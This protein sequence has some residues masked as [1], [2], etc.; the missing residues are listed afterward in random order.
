MK[1]GLQTLLAGIVITTAVAGVMKLSD[2]ETPPQIVINE[3]CGRNGTI[4]LGNGSRVEDYIELYNTTDQTICLEDWCLSDDSEKLDKYRLGDLT[5]APHGFLILYA[6]GEAADEYSLNFKISASGENLFLTDPEGT[7]ADQIYVPELEMDCVYARTTDGGEEWSF[8]EASAGT[9]NQEAAEWKKAV[10]DAPGFSH[11][12]GFYEEGFYLTLSA[13][14]GE[15]IYYTTDGSVPTSDSFLYEE[16]IFVKNR[17]EEEN[18]LNAEVRMLADWMDYEASDEKADKATVIRAVA[19]DAEDQVS[20]VVTA[21]YFV[22]LEQYKDTKVLSIVAEPQKLLGEDG[23]FVTGTAYDAWYLKDPMSSDGVFSPNWTQNYELTNYWG[24]GRAYEALSEVQLFDSGEQVL[25]QNAGVRVRGN[26]TRLLDKKSLKLVSRKAY[27]GSR[28]FDHEFFPQTDSHSLYISAYLEKAYCIGL[29]EGRNM[30]WQQTEEC[31]VFINGEYW[32]TAAVMEDYD[33]LYLE[34]HFGVDPENVILIKDMEASAG[35]EYQYLYDEVLEYLRDETV[36]QTEKCVYMYEHFDV[37]N[38]IDWLCFN[39]Y[40]GNHDLTYKRNSILWRTV[41][42]ED[43]PYGDCKWRL[44]VWDIDRAASEADPAETDLWNYKII[45]DNRFYWALRESEHFCR[46]FVLTMMD[47]INSNF[48]IE[49]VERVL[50]EWG[51]NASYANGFFT[52][53]PEY[54]MEALRQEFDLYGSVEE[55]TL[56]VNDP[57]AGKIYINTMQAEVSEEPWSGQYFTD[58]PVTVTASAEPGYR[59]AGWSGS[60]ESTDETMEVSVLEGGIS[61][62][63][64]FEKIE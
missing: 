37:Q 39:L 42:P 7:I 40:L 11:E 61:L 2:K 36:S 32:Y 49:N 24:R 23:I 35:E 29:A 3:V 5:I 62:T 16:Q 52:K 6:D 1:K 33:E 58:Y 26:Y 31:A 50:G 56:Q 4:L 10:L 64:V 30:G 34:Q 44:L 9:S 19:V 14:K 60:Y 47:M 48:S 41:E 25:D 22:G 57:E 13:K 20:E 54:M 38:M 45:C 59:F 8:L 51:L 55:V 17:S 63:A 43:S 15:K 46:Q 18:V 21:V 28:T 53:R 12:S 27:S